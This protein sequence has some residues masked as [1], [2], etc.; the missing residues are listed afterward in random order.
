[1]KMRLQVM[2][3]GGTEGK[4]EYKFCRRMQLDKRPRHGRGYGL[5]T[6]VPELHG[7]L[8]TSNEN[9]IQVSSRVE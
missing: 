8:S 6:D 2:S 7:P 4:S 5:C 3:V 1:M 9:F